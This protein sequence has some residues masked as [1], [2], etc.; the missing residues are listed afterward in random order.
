VA[1]IWRLD[2][3]DQLRIAELTPMYRRG[4]L[5]FVDLYRVTPERQRAIIRAVIRTSDCQILGGREIIYGSADGKNDV[6]LSI[7]QLDPDLKEY[8]ERLPLNPEVPPDDAEHVGRDC[9]RVG[10]LDN[11]VNYLIPQIAKALAR[12]KHGKIIGYDYWEEDRRP[13]DYGVPS[14]DDPRISMF[15]P[16]RHGTMVASIFVQEASADSVCLAVYRY[17]PADD[18]NKI[19]R[20]IS[21]MAKDG[22]RIVSV[23]SGRRRQWPEFSSAMKAHPNMLFVLSAGNEGVDL[24]DQPFYPAAYDAENAIVVAASD[25]MDRLWQQSNR[26]EGIVDLAVDAVNLP[27]FDFEGRKVPLTGTSFAAPRVAGIAARMLADNPEWSTAQAKAQIDKLARESAVRAEGIPV[28][29]DEVLLRA[30]P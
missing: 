29:T 11:G 9:V 26:G 24:N 27:G 20:I 25:H 3:R 2:D 18:E 21:E 4:A 10:L 19:G 23:S 12:D 16:R 17:L 15:S 30:F 7:A 6:P 1:Q 28:L 8:A 13:F 5:L 14:T 22:V